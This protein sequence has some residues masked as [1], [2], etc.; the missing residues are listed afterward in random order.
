MG[1]LPLIKGL[2]VRLTDHIDRNL[3]LYKQTKC[4]IHGWTLNINENTEKNEIERVLK[5][6]PDMI[7]L[8]FEKATWQIHKDL[9]QGVYPMKVTGKAWTISEGTKIKAKRMGFHIVPD[10]GQ[11]AHSVQGASLAAVI[12][13]CL[14]VDLCSR[15]TEMLAAYIGLSRVRRKEALLIAEPFSP[16]LFCHGQPP[17]PE[18]LMKVLRRDITA[19]D[20]KKDIP[21]F[22]SQCCCL[23]R[24]ADKTDVRGV[25]A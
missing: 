25:L 9:E 24:S 14:A 18:I 1:L 13:D 19:D 20:A 21:C 3:G 6:Q 22:L 4:T 2:P 15:T 7:Y 11:T 23:S 12:V 10:F 16:A 8:K 17:G 5:F